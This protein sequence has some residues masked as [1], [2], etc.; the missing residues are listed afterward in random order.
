MKRAV[1]AVALLAAA[2]PAARA[3]FADGLAA[4]DGGDYASALTEW[5]TLADEGDAEAQTAIAGLYRYGQGVERDDMEAARWY[6]RAAEQGEVNAQLNLGEMY[7]GGLGMPR[8]PV[9]AYLWLSLAATQGRA[10]AAAR[11]DELART[12]TAAQIAQARNLIEAW[13][14][15]MP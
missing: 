6:L 8:D 2:H 5:R 15:K 4:Y 12:M 11:R 13:V 1:L 14:P 3:D 10:W 9:Q 7:A